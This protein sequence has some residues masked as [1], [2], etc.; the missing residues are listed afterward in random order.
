MQHRAWITL[1]AFALL[2]SITS[3]GCKPHHQTW[4]IG[5]N[6]N[7]TSLDKQQVIQAEKVADKYI[8][9]WIKEDYQTMYL[10]RSEHARF[11]YK[12]FQILSTGWRT[13]GF[14][15]VYGFEP[16][17]PNISVSK[18]ELFTY[19]SDG[20]AKC[21]FALCVNDGKTLD[22][23][24]SKDWPERVALLRYDIGDKPCGM[25]MVLD[26]GKWFATNNP[27]EWEGAFPNKFWELLRGKTTPNGG[28]KT[29]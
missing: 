18:P 10:L 15:H 27:G 4:V 1:L 29:N 22:Q 11:P 7:L 17:A 6:G 23:I 20:Q 12:G 21:L 5:S 2:L 13:K 9:S 28:T 19:L 3:C 26:Q 16:D 8:D 14:K 24:K 25:L